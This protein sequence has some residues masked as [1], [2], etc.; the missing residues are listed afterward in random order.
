MMKVKETP[1]Y[2]IIIPC[3]LNNNDVFFR[4]RVKGGTL[5]VKIHL[6]LWFSCDENARVLGNLY[7]TFFF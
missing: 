2:I 7:F 3:I 1:Q 6:L 4:K 5:R